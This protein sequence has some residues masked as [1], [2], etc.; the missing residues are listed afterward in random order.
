MS[1]CSRSLLPPEPAVAVS[2]NNIA[3]SVIVIDE[4]Q[5]LPPDFLQPVLDVLRLLTE[6]YGVTLVLTTATQPALG[7]TKD[8]AW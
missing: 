4:A 8:A 6:H 3:N 2:C 7:S 1:S 5:L